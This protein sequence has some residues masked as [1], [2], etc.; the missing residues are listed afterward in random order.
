LQIGD[1]RHADDADEE[2]QPPM[3]LVPNCDSTLLSHCYFTSLQ[4][5]PRYRLERGAQKIASKSKEDKRLNV[6]SRDALLLA[7]RFGERR[8]VRRAPYLRVYIDPARR[9]F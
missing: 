5:T 4:K 3:R 8:Y 1:H 2:L 6:N 9:A 7:I